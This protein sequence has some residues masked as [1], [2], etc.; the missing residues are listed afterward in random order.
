M[1][2]GSDAGCGRDNGLEKS[3]PASLYHVAISE[4]E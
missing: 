1:D 3:E 2:E 4:M